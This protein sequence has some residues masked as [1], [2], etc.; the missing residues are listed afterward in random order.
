MFANEITKFV[1]EVRALGPIEL[2]HKCQDK[3]LKFRRR[4][5]SSRGGDRHDAKTQIR[6][7]LGRL[8]RRL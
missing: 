4:A 6:H 7:V 8:L 1:E 3:L 2:G 5:I